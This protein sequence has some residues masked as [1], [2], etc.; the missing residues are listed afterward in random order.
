[1]PIGINLLRTAAWKYRVA[2]TLG[3]AVVLALGVYC[4][5]GQRGSGQGGLDKLQ[6]V[7]PAPLN[8]P[9]FTTKQIMQ[10]IH[11][12][13]NG[14]ESRRKTATR[15]LV[16]AGDAGLPLMKMRLNGLTTPPLRHALRSAIGG[17]AQA[18]MLRGPL[19]TLQLRNVPL[20]R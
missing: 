9:Q 16:A 20:P 17:I 19:V 6:V 18:D 8:V 4:C 7:M 2:A 10:W 14:R 12:L 13:S 1:M 15:C 5:D 3:L 11:D